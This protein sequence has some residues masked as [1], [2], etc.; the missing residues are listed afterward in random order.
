MKV[1]FWIALA[2]TAGMV[3]ATQACAPEETRAPEAEASPPS[4]IVRG[5]RLFVPV[6]I[7]GAETEA[8]LDSGAEMSFA[9][10]AF[11]IKRLMRVNPR[12]PQTAAEILEIYRA[13]F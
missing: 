10:K 9:D 1:S 11:A 5:D 3:L 2:G 13:A 7:N 12:V 8:V 6:R 4:L